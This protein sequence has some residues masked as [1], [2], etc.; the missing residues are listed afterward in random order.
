MTFSIK[1]VIECPCGAAVV[2]ARMR[3]VLDAVEG[4]FST[5]PTEQEWHHLLPAWF[6]DACEPEKAAPES[7]L[8]NHKRV[9]MTQTEIVE[10]TLKA[11]SLRSWLYW[12]EPSESA[13]RWVNAVVISST[14]LEV[15]VAVED[16]P[17]P[18]EAFRWLA[19]VAGATAID[20]D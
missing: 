10:A 3:E 20:D 18:F 16:W 13:W 14:T 15:E 19:R 12:M 2:R 17:A 6:V 1:A 7:E 8:A 4:N 9:E 11:W 5:W